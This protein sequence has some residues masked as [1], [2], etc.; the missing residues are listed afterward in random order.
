MLVYYF[1]L[2]NTYI[3]AVHGS[4]VGCV[5]AWYADCRGFNPHVRQHSLVGIGNEIISMAILSLLL[6]QEGQLSVNGKT[7]CIS[8]GKLS[9][10]EEALAQEQCG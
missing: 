2:L 5:S 7:V 10:I 3:C 4:L 8:T 9:L 1:C 6:I